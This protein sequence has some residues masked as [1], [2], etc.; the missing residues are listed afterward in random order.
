MA[1]QHEP[2]TSTTPSGD[3]P[4]V[5][6]VEGVTKRFPGVLAND[7]INL[8]LH[9]GEILALLGENGAGKSTLMNIIYGLYHQD[10]G[11]IRLKGEEVRF[12][13]PR[14]AIHS[15]IGMVHQHFQLV[16]VM[17][18]AEN[19]I[20]GEENTVART[21]PRK[22][23]RKIK[24]LPTFA[25]I[26]ERL[27]DFILKL[28]PSIVLFLLIAGV[29][30]SLNNTTYAVAGVIIGVAMGALMAL[31]E[32]ARIVWGFAWRIGLAL[33]ALNLATQ[34]ELITRVGITS[35]ALRHEITVHNERK[36]KE[37]DEGFTV[38]RAMV[39]TDKINF[40]W[41]K[42]FRDA[43]DAGTGIDGVIASAK[44]QLEEYRD[45]GIPGGL[46][47][48]IDDVPPVANGIGLA[49]FLFLLGGHS[50]ATWR[51]T[52]TLPRRL[53]PVDLALMGGIALVYAGL[54]W[55]NLDV[56]STGARI[57]L[58]AALVLG[59]GFVIWRMIQQRGPQAAE[60][61]LGSASPLDSV[62]DSLLVLMSTL[63]EVGD[64]KAAADRV[65]ELSQRYGLEVDPDAV[66]E[67][68][69]VG[70]QQRVEIIKALY[71]KADIL[72]LDEPTA[73]LTPQE[74]KELFK[75]MRELA[76][77]GVTIIF[78]T[79]KLKEVFEV[80]TKIVVMRGGA[81]VGT[82]APDQATETSLAAMMVGREV[83][84]QVEKD[85]AHPTDPVLT[86]A[87]LS[88]IDNRGAVALDDVGF[89]VRAGE[90]LG[91][92]GVQGNGQTE[93]V[94][95]LTGLREA[96]HGSVQ[97]LGTE[98]LPDEQPD[99]PLTDRVG[100]LV[101]DTLIT[102]ILAYF[103]GFFVWYFRDGSLSLVGIILTVLAVDAT[104]HLGS[105]LATGRKPWRRWARSSWTSVT[106]KRRS[107][108]FEKAW[109]PFVP[110]TT[111]H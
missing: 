32:I 53:E 11:T 97:I 102:A 101:L 63:T 106:A 93:L 19:V 37:M 5:L 84:L 87:G 99:A 9:Q 48:A 10:E 90:V 7:N 13:S 89:E 27:P 28:L 58:F 35:V 15:G 50:L 107:A 77:Q 39:E 46:I 3:N 92:A 36:P 8:T 60:T 100:A 30:L 83:I 111:E 62:I 68:L 95:V 31:P 67:K 16:N 85:E 24:G 108:Y 55:F 45:N 33:V 94:E 47:D 44:E 96:T 91:I 14:E 1:E 65:R 22:Q 34:V 21:T 49:V 69:P 105:W 74:G 88:A 59:L 25:Q 109:P 66:I 110:T 80:A 82:T 42:E 103:V 51:G 2:N 20:L 76:A 86:V 12:A 75:I 57:G 41:S 52:S 23:H 56:V 64:T 18:V 72:I 26:I 81:V 78:I 54:A 98:L 40:Q 43:N 70:A 17:T 29:A 79:H 38:K 73:V 6:E 4:V 104:W 61:V 71:R